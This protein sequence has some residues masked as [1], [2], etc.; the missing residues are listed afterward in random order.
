MAAPHDL[1][2]YHIDV[3]TTFL[4]GELEEEIYTYQPNKFELE[5]QG[6]V[7]KHLSSDMRSSIELC[8]LLALLRMKPIDACTIAMM[9]ER[10]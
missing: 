9:E 3:K 5:G 6:M 2:I 7:C 1:L 8:Y 10:E 4:N